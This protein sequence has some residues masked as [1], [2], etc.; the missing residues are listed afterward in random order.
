M[1]LIEVTFDDGGNPDKGDV[2]KTVLHYVGIVYMEVGIMWFI[3]REITKRQKLVEE[4][5]T[6]ENNDSLK[7]PI[8]SQA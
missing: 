3:L 4:V 1:A 7:A 6:E 2:L 8:E 5:Q